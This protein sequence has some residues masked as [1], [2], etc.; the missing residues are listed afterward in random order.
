MVF[1]QFNARRAIQQFNGAA[2]AN[3]TVFH[4]HFARPICKVCMERVAPAWQKVNRSS[5]I[6]LLAGF[7]LRSHLV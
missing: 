2:G 6:S 5:N 7:F 1:Q 4:E 3:S